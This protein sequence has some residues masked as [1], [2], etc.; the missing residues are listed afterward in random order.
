MAFRRTLGT[1][2]V[3]T[4][5]KKFLRG[6]K[7]Y[8]GIDILWMHFYTVASFSLSGQ[9]RRIKK[10]V[11]RAA[12]CCSFEFVFGILLSFLVTNKVSEHNFFLFSFGSEL[13]KPQS[14]FKFI[15]KCG[16]TFWVY[17][18]NNE[19]QR[20]EPTLKARRPRNHL[21]LAVAGRNA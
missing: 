6:Q 9:R 1:L 18:L 12:K 19:Q 15:F 21:V 16:N 4:E 8:L 10:R 3:G 17:D 11:S 5:N 2:R 20:R 13:N 14:E 7:L